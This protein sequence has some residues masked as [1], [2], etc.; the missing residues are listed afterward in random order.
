MIIPIFV[1][2]LISSI[3]TELLKLFPA[4]KE[5]KDRMRITAF[6]V[7]LVLSLAYLFSQEALL[8]EGVVT[9]IAGSLAAT[10]AVYKS[11]VQPIEGMFR[12]PKSKEK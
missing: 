12:H 10:F 5:T 4:L 9:L 8:T 11:I 6:V 7:T 1:I 2:G 3:V